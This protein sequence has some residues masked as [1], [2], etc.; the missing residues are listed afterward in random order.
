MSPL[1]IKMILHI[2]AIV[3]D[4]RDQPDARHGHSEA[5]RETLESFEASGLIE[6]SFP[7]E[8]WDAMSR[9]DRP[10]QYHITEKGTAFVEALCAVKLPVIK[11][12]QP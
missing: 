3:T 11:W 12:M 2:Y 8:V 6:Q 5:V 4:Y 1:E 7:D 9:S 10:S